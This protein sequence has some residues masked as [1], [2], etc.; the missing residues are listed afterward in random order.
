VID[1]ISA[2]GKVNAP[3]PHRVFW[4]CFEGLIAIALIL[5][6]GLAALQAMSVSTGLPFTFVLLFG[7]ISLFK[8]LATEPR[9]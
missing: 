1:T 5:G 8:G 4:A 6:G 3:S 9:G 7:C 2:G